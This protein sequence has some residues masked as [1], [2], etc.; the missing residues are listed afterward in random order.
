G[1]RKDEINGVDYHFLTTEEFERRLKAGDFLEHAVVYGKHYGMPKQNVTAAIAQGKDLAINIDVQGASTIR[2][3]AK[4]LKLKDLGFE[5]AGDA[6]LS[7]ILVSVFVMPASRTQL[8]ERLKKRGTDDA[9]TI[10]RRLAAV[11]Q[12]MQRW[13][14]YDY[15]ITS[16][17]L[18]EDL[19]QLQGILTAERLRTKRLTKLV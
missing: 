9:A 16:G 3:R 4:E 15:V 5:S 8:E 7:D 19:R 12:E 14:E 18:F 2:N 17:A 10:Q 6:S 1:P 13:T 11:R